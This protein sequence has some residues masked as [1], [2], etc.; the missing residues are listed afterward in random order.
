[1]AG[2]MNNHTSNRRLRAEAIWPNG[3]TKI[4]EIKKVILCY[5]QNN[6]SWPFYSQA[7]CFHGG[8]LKAQLPDQ[9]IIGN[10]GRGAYYGIA[11]NTGNSQNAVINNDFNSPVPVGGIQNENVIFAPSRLNFVGGFDNQINN[12]NTT[13]DAISNLVYG[14][15][16][17]VKGSRNGFALGRQ[18]LIHQSKKFSAIGFHN[19]IDDVDEAYAIGS[20]TR[21]NG[22]DRQV[23]I[24]F[25][26]ISGSGSFLDGVGN[27]SLTFGTNAQQ[28]FN[29]RPST[30][31]QASNFEQPVTGIGITEPS[32]KLEIK[33]RG[34]ENKAAKALSILNSDQDPL[35]N[36]REDGA[37][38]FNLP[39]NTRTRAPYQFEQSGL[40]P[41]RDNQNNP[42]PG[43][44]ANIVQNYNAF[45]FF[46]DLN[47]FG[48]LDQAKWLALGERPPATD[49]AQVAYGLANVWQ[50]N[51]GNFVL[52]DQT[53]KDT[54]ASEAK[55]L[56]VTFQDVGSNG[57]LTNDSGR[58]RLRFLFRNSKNIEDPN[59]TFELMS[60]EPT[61][62]VG[63][64]DYSG[65]STQQA[66][67]EV[68]SDTFDT[69]D[70]V[71]EVLDSASANF[72]G[73]S[74]LVATDSG[75]VG[76]G[77][78]S[79]SEKLVVDGNIFPVNNTSNTISNYTLG[80]SMNVWKDVF[81]KNGQ[82][83]SSDRRLKSNI[84]SLTYGIEEIM[85]LSPV[86]YKFKESRN[87]EI[88][89]GLIA[90]QLEKVIQEPVETGDGEKQMKGVRYKSLIPVL[91]NGMQEQQKQVQKQQQKIQ[92]LQ[93]NLEQEKA[94][95]AALEKK[96]N[97]LNEKVNQLAEQVNGVSESFKKADEESL[98]QK[99]A[100]LS[101]EDADQAMLLQNRPNPY[102]NETVIPYYLPRNAQNANMLITNTQGQMLK[103]IRLE[104]TGK[105]ELT[106]QTADLNKGQYQYTLIIDGRQIQTRKMIVK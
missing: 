91:I 64:G 76:I 105:G 24:G 100:T 86:S 35:F 23:V 39:A 29:I 106:L 16:N 10:Q 20:K 44:E 4:R 75:N 72:R 90:Q 73:N 82:V 66:N 25:G 14:R 30:I 33:N 63:V 101:N 74:V 92:K 55:D 26:D 46:K 84:D 3:L 28:T 71:F 34:A 56:A 7:S 52:L 53:P 57:E 31:G 1:M 87:N 60:L 37:A 18:N 36:V 42:L 97:K 40:Q 67:L 21:I 54:N 5:K 13:T 6:F 19:K 59:S 68:K 41:F 85:Q 88:H 32:A 78:S 96:V 103:R 49:S 58:N 89:L 2:T 77:T 95:K 22:S 61:G 93:A 43:G 69:G 79:P 9:S 83:S 98:N 38:G 8:G 50:N 81:V 62:E 11:G 48:N 102:S 45:P 104:G 27:K 99:T 80:N 12:N 94:E 70:P 17:F 65:S 47:P 15:L 51:A